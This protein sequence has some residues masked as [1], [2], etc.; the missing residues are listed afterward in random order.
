MR[1]HDW[2]RIFAKLLKEGMIVPEIFIAKSRKSTIGER[3]SHQCIKK[4]KMEQNFY[5]DGKRLI[6]M[7]TFLL[8]IR[9][10]VKYE[11]ILQAY[12]L[13]SAPGLN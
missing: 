3:V 10:T 12:I 8:K 9:R 4:T 13:E 7:I 6:L 2:M 1:R 5:M 11:C